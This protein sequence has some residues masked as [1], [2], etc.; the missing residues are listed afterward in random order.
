[1]M[2]IIRSSLI[3]CNIPDQIVIINNIT[4]FHFIRQKTFHN[5]MKKGSS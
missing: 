4:S 3:I 2:K 5:L 1:M